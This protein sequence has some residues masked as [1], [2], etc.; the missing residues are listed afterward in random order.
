VASVSEKQKIT[1]SISSAA[2]LSAKI[3]VGGTVEVPLPWVAISTEQPSA[4]SEAII[5]VNPADSEFV[6]RLL[7]DGEWEAVPAI[8]GEKGDKGDQGIQGPVGPQGEKGDSPV[9]GVDYFTDDDKQEII[10]TVLEKLPSAESVS[11]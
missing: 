7:V 6:L 2:S 4:D 9:V 11:V 1:A 8:Q 10:N 5:W 3:N